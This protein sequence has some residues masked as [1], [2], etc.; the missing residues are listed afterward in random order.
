MPRENSRKLL[1]CV[2]GRLSG[3]TAVLAST[4]TDPSLT[5]HVRRAA[6]D[7]EDALVWL[8]K[9]DLDPQPHILEVAE[10]ALQLADRRLTWIEENADE[11]W[12]RREISSI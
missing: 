2:A 8:A 3:R 6:C 7:I 11:Q 5:Q 9:A 4:V 10:S 1:L 12:L